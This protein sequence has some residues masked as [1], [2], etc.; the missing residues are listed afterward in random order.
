MNLS[1]CTQNSVLSLICIWIKASLNVYTYMMRVNFFFKFSQ[2]FY[3]KI[4]QTYKKVKEQYNEHSQTF[5]P[6]SPIANILP[7][8]QKIYRVYVCY[9]DM[10]Y[11]QSYIGMLYRCIC[12]YF[13]Y[14]YSFIFCR[15]IGKYIIDITPLCPAIL[16]CVF[17][18]NHNSNFTPK[19]ISSKLII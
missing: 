1:F 3:F 19:K 9:I 6:N 10:L 11:R 14:I 18:C 16:A 13:T 2:F 8:V 5:H 12:I 15:T 17:P 7:H 4:L